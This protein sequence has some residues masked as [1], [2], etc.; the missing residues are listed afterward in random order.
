MQAVCDIKYQAARAVT[1]KAIP[2]KKIQRSFTVEHKSG[3]R[4]FAQKSKSIWGDVD[5]RSVARDVLASDA[6][7]PQADDRNLEPRTHA[8]LS[9]K[10]PSKRDL[11]RPIG[12]LE[13]SSE[14]VRPPVATTLSRVTAADAG[15]ATQA[16]PE[17]VLAEQS[18]HEHAPD[19]TDE[20]NS[21]FPPKQR[22]ARRS[23][24][25]RIAVKADRASKLKPEAEQKRTASPNPATQGGLD[26]SDLEAENSR[27][28]K[29]LADKLRAE[30]ADL[31]R[32]L[33]ID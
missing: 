20:A 33:N 15:A 5:L 26:L 18:H 8:A 9:L 13:Q 11:P 24:S 29:L 12:E 31:R 1:I 32:R 22:K 4:K 19:P 10:R 23:T 3:R 2:L 17:V 25:Q 14:L 27:L 16:A 21:L 30:N 28:R 6:A 7:L